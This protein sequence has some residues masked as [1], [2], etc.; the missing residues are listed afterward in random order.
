MLSIDLDQAWVQN[1]AAGQQHMSNET[2]SPGAQLC[3]L[4]VVP[5]WAQLW[6]HTLRLTYN[7]QVGIR[8]RKPASPVHLSAACDRRWRDFEA[9]MPEQDVIM[10]PHC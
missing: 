8:F 2:E 4:Q 3:V 10:V 6:L 5:W 7:G 9:Q 1:A